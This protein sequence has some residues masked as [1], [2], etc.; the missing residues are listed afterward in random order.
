MMAYLYVL[1]GLISNY[2][3]VIIIMDITIKTC[4]NTL[5]SALYFFLWKRSLNGKRLCQLQRSWHE[6][7]VLVKAKQLSI[8]LTMLQQ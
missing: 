3:Y 4:I 8:L 5:I 7:F 1:H 6:H 2:L